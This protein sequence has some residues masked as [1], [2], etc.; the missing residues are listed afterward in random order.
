MPSYSEDYSFCAI[1]KKIKIASLMAK[2]PK[3]WCLRFIH[4][5]LRTPSSNPT[6]VSLQGRKQAKTRTS[7]NFKAKR[8]NTSKNTP[9][10]VPN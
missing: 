4:P 9:I 8:E 10:D 3:I 1:K 6:K 5:M 2:M 7:Q